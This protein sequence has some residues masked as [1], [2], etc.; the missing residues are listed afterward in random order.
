MKKIPT[1]YELD[2]KTDRYNIATQLKI[3]PIEISNSF[4]NHYHVWHEF[5]DGRAKSLQAAKLKSPEPALI[6]GSGPTADAGLPLLKNWKGAIF[7]STS[8]ATTCVYH[9][10]DPTYIILLDPRTPIDE[11]NRIDTWDNRN[12]ALVLHPCAPHEYVKYWIWKKYY[13]REMDPTNHFYSTV[14][15]TAY[16]FITTFHMLFSCTAAAQ[17]S[18]AHYLGYDPLFLTGVDFGYPFK[19]SRFTMWYYEKGKWCSKEPP[20]IKK[21]VGL[22]G[23]FVRAN[24]GILSNTIQMFYKRSF[25]AT[26]RTDRGQ[27]INTND[28]GTITELP[29]PAG[30]LSEVIEKQGRGFESIYLS[31]QGIKDVTEKYL[32]THRICPLT[33]HGKTDDGKSIEYVRLVEVDDWKE[34]IPKYLEGLEKLDIKDFDKDA[35]IARMEWLNGQTQK[36]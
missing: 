34:Q 36:E 28:K 26:I 32:F 14:L 19:R 23:T 33:M 13:Y 16:D 2:Q 10:K 31:D 5:K 12:S 27:V 6:I 22:H 21:N 20:S 8:Q 1:E 25:L 9:G 3:E 17:I 18:L 4:F 29:V 11:L 15:A 24:S 35:I 7:T 30:G